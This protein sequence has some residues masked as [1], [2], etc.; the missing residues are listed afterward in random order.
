VG[1]S[2]ESGFWR[3]FHIDILPFL[4]VSDLVRGAAYPFLATIVSMAFGSLLPTAIDLPPGGGSETPAGQWALKFK[5]RILFS[6]LGLAFLLYLL[7]GENG[8]IAAS[9][10]L[11]PLLAGLISNNTQIQIIVPDYKIRSF[12]LTMGLT[13]PLLLFLHGAADAGEIISGVRFQEISF[14]GEEGKYR[15]LSI[16]DKY[17]FLKPDND[18]NII[19]RQL[20]DA[21]KISLVFHENSDYGRP[22]LLRLWDAVGL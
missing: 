9:V 4:T 12:I 22:I 13:A 15:L 19:I 17:I 2:Y 16:T 14:P 6:W 11:L 5:K 20:T 10:C 3:A 1:I 18:R 7:G 8:W 21:S